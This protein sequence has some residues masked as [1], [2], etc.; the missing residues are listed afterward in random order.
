MGT[1][2]HAYV[3]V[4]PG[5]FPEKYN[6]LTVFS[7]ASSDWEVFS[8]YHADLGIRLQSKRIL[9]NFLLFLKLPADP[10]CLNSAMPNW[11]VNTEVTF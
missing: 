2:P 3:H 5:T 9:A 7:L 8:C 1:N 4:A 10:G 11:L 6:P